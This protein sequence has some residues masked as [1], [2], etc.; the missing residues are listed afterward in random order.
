MF[1]KTRRLTALL[2]RYGSPLHVVDLKRLAANAKAFRA[3]PRGRPRGCD[4]Y[5]SYKTNPVPGVLRVLAEAGVGAEV[6]SEYELWLALRLGVPA[7]RIVF[8]GPAKTDAAIERAT[9]EGVG[10]INVNHPEEIGRLSAA[11]VRHGKTTRVGLRVTAG[12]AWGRQFG[13]PVARSQAVGVFAQMLRAPGLHAVAVQAHYGHPIRSRATLLAFVDAVLGFT[14][15]VRAKFGS[16][17]EV[18]DLGGSLALPN[19]HP[20]RTPGSRG[21]LSVREYVAELWDRVERHHARGSRRAPSIALEPG[22]ALSGDCQALLTR[23]VDVRVARGR[24][25]AILDAGTNLAGE[26]RYERHPIV[27]LARRP[28]ARTRD[29]TLTGP[30]CSPADVLAEPVALPELR[31]GDALA[32]LDAG[33]YFVPSSTTFSYP[34][35]AIVAIENGGARLLRRAETFEDLLMLDEEDQPCDDQPRSR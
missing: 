9:L 28:G 33:A 23:V 30:L 6:V 10:L 13:V 35:P 3:A 17:I 16:E 4:V 5:F 14:D 8:N 20:L 18:L 29:Y 15:H 7:S 1:S 32:I 22:R 24:S 27:P 12:G 19:V 34:R 31:R 26:L 25:Y 2:E 21:C 11:A